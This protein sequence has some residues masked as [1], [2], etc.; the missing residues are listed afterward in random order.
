MSTSSETMYFRIYR[1]INQMMRD[2]GYLVNPANLDLQI[3]KFRN[4]FKND[5]RNLNEVFQNANGDRIMACF[6]PIERL[7]TKT[8]QALVKKMDDSAVSRMVLVGENGIATS[9][10]LRALDSYKSAGKWIE[11]FEF[12]EVVINITE[13]ELVPKHEPLTDEEKAE[14]LARYNVK[15]TQLPRILRTDPVSKYL[16]VKPG[17]VLKITRKSDT[18]GSY[19]TYRLVY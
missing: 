18:A 2:R 7:D 16:G 10:A 11:F 9:T 15:E 3:E 8:V 1:T 19:V 6:D 12:D 13:H 5:P 14:V 17:Q 4:I